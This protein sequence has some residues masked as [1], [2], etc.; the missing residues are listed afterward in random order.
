MKNYRIPKRRKPADDRFHK[1]GTLPALRSTT[2]LTFLFSLLTFGLPALWVS[3]CSKRTESDGEKEVEVQ[4]DSAYCNFSVKTGGRAVERLDIFIYEAGGTGKLEYHEKYTR[5]Q[6]TYEIFLPEGEK[7]VMAIA[8]SPHNFRTSSLERFDSALLIAY[9]YLEDNPEKPIMGAWVETS[10]MEAELELVPL[11]CKVEIESVS[12]DLDNYELL[13][14]PRVRLKDL[15]ASAKVFDKAGFSPTETITDGPW[16]DFPHDIGYYPM[17][18][19]ISLFCYPNDTAENVL[20]TAHTYLQ[21]ECSIKGKVH[22]YDI[23]LPPIERNATTK[24]SFGIDSNSKLLI[25]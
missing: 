13:E 8:N 6:E 24:I 14:N 18:P 1:T 4:I 19:D 20:G 22:S 3:S 2:I 11:L 9:Q 7:R 16:V 17:K 23:K 12:N 5:F 21:F 10:N 15:N 25:F